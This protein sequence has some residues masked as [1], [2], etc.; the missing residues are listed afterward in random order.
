VRVALVYHDF[1]L[2][3]SLAR[4]RV[5]LARGLVAEGLEVHCYCNPE[6]RGVEPNGVRFHD[7]RPTGRSEARF[8]QALEHG[9]FAWKATR[10]VR[11]HR[12][13][14]DV[15]D[16]LGTAAWEHDVIRAAAVPVSEQARWPER[17]GKSVRAARAR[18]RFA[19]VLHPALGV[20]RVTQSRQFR[21]GCYSAVAAVSEEVS[22]DLQRV[23][24]VPPERITVIAPPIEV[25]DG[26]NGN[27]V[28]L[29]RRLGLDERQYLVLFVGHD[30][31]R[32]GLDDAITAVAAASPETHLAVVGG[33]NEL[34]YRAAAD[35]SGAGDRIHFLG[36]TSEPHRYFGDADVFI[37]PTREEV[38]GTTVIEAMAAGVPVITTSVAGVAVEVERSGAGLVVE[39]GSTAGLKDAL[40]SLLET[41][42]RREEMGK[43][44]L[45]AARR[46]GQ[47]A[48]ARAMINIYTRA[49]DQRRGNGGAP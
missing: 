4:G 38:W 32:K 47:A 28:Q 33:G 36:V 25:P 21:P 24:R 46:Y 43:R 9:S 2:E 7:V 37:L 12:A 45:G 30:F 23:H 35:R 20:A 31:E 17:G 14:Y 19:H 22:A 48:H 5:L 29:R 8:G 3:A 6:T 49:V 42:V 13:R 15:I 26:A 34:P 39:N 16:V 1:H 18:A 27:S 44:G 11:E 41:P 10:L 40:V